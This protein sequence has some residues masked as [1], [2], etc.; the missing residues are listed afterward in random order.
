VKK[1]KKKKTRPKEK[2]SHLQTGSKPTLSDVNN[3]VCNK[4]PEKFHRT[5]RIL[6]VETLQLSLSFS[7]PTM[8]KYLQ[9]PT[10]KPI[11]SLNE[12]E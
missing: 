12:E 6:R 8:Q 2:K 4:H 3:K 1:K 9:D 11:L 5:L 7:L 10:P